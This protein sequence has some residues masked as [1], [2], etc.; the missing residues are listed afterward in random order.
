LHR[1]LCINT[2]NVKNKVNHTGKFNHTINIK[3]NKV[4]NIFNKTP[5]NYIIIYEIYCK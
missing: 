3:Q 2:Q 5:F 4:I 1:V